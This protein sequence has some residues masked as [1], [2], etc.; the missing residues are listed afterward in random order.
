MR[1]GLVIIICSIIIVFA[2]WHDFIFSNLSEKTEII[3]YWVQR[4]GIWAPL[5]YIFGFVLRPLVF[6]PATPV[7]IL[8]GFLFGGLWGTIY[9]LIGV[10]CSSTCEFLLVR[11]FLGEKTKIF[12]REKAR[13]LNQLVVK[14]GFSTVFL[15]RFI[16][17]VAF[18]L[19]NCGLALMPIKFKHYFYG[20][21]L[22][23]LPA[24]IFY[25]F[26]GNTALN[27]SVPGKI[28]ILVTLGS[29][30]YILYFLLSTRINFKNE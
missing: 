5:A 4:L 17:N 16:P 6:L 29:C 26:F 12:L 9:V 24:S 21:F 1:I 15:V 19:Q 23:C 27:W 3:K 2:Q 30:F 13:A 18:D 8:G 7:A 28:G 22:G 20:T 11:Y 14:H 10:M 25:V